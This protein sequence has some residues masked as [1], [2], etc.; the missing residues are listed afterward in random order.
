MTGDCARFRQV[1]PAAF[2]A[3]NIASIARWSFSVTAGGR[4]VRVLGTAFSVRLDSIEA[5][6][7]HAGRRKN[8]RPAG[9]PA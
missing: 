8:H 5:A 7:V 3:E 1:W 9:L 2:Y 6:R 4:V